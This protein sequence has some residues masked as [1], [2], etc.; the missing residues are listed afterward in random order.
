MGV[1]PQFRPVLR[2]SSGQKPALTLLTRT[3]QLVRFGYAPEGIRGAL[4]FWTWKMRQ[5][6]QNPAAWP[7]RHPQ[8]WPMTVLQRSKYRPAQPQGLPGR[9]TTGVS[10]HIANANGATGF[11]CNTPSGHCCLLR[12]QR[13][14]M[15][16]IA[17]RGTTRRQNSIGLFRTLIKGPL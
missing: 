5:A 10:F 12:Q 9:P 4:L 15:I 1:I 13:R 11:D 7:M 17:S 6:H 14:D 2:P 8:A 16:F 3:L